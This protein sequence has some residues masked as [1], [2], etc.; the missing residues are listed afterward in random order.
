[1]HAFRAGFGL[2][3]RIIRAAPDALLPLVTT[4]LFALIFLSIVRQSGRPDL[5]PDALMAPVLMTLWWIALQ[6]AGHMI[7]GDRWQALLEPLLAT[8]ASLAG[9]LLGRITALMCLGLLSFFEVWAVGELVFGVS[10][11]FEHPVALGLT[12]LVTA[13]A[14]AGTSVAFAAVFVLTRNAYTFT[15]SLSYPLYLLGGVFVPV[16][17]LPGW[18][19]PVSSGVFM[20]WSADL[21]RASLKPPAIDDLWQRIGMVVLLGALSFLVGRAL[22]FHVLRR[23]RANGELAAA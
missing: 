5:Q 6:H 1:M 21:L 2:E 22:L 12:L 13:F 16:A 20:S 23:M 18:L 15:N 9:V 3:A 11:P 7:T 19:Q 14:T 17:I 10:I 8:P 4:P